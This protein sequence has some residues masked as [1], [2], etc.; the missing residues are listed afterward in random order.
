V[1]G[2]SSGFLIISLRSCRSCDLEVLSVLFPH[3]ACLPVEWVFVAG[4]SV[5]IR[6]KTVCPEAACPACGVVSRRVHSRYE[7]R[8][9]D[10]A[11]AGRETLRPM[12]GISSSRS[13]AVAKGAIISSI[14]ASS[15]AMSALIASTR[16]S[17]LPSRKAW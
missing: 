16:A 3:L 13:A 11:I 14:L 10:T 6:A 15:S 9:S 2:V 5:R 12:P 7:R 4:K 1:L 8:L 17:I